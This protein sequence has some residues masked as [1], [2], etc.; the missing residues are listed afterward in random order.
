MRSEMIVPEDS[1][2]NRGPTT[3]TGNRRDQ[4]QISFNSKPKDFPS[5]LFEAILSCELVGITLKD[6]IPGLLVPASSH[7]TRYA[8]KPEDA[9]SRIL[10]GLRP[11]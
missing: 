1:G 11:H 7:W 3:R 5:G 2:S 6:A 8:W 9:H 4:R 10:L